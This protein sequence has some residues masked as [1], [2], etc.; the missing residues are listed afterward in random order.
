MSSI[1]WIISSTLG[2]DEVL[3]FE[4]NSASSMKLITYES[5]YSIILNQNQKC[6]H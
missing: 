4:V 2:M 1:G 6:P 5:K 3:N